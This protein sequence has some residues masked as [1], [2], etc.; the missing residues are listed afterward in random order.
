MSIPYRFMPWA[1]R[2]L[3]R[4][5]QNKDGSNVE[6]AVRPKI[7]VGLT[8][9]AKQDGKLVSPV[10][11]NVNLTLYGPGDVIGIDQRLIVRT[12]P[13][14]NITNFEPNYL[15]VIDFDPPD[16]PWLLTP[17]NANANHQL[18]P[19]LVLV[20]LDRSIVTTPP[21]VKAGQPLPSISLTAE[22]VA[23]ELPNLAES[24]LW[25]HTQAVLNKNDVAPDPEKETARV[26][27]ELE[28][29][30]A[31][32]VSRLVCPRRLQPRK[33]YLAC[34]VPAFEAGRM[35]G[36]GQ[37]LPPTMTTLTPAWTKGQ[38]RELPVYYHWEFSTGPVGDIE[39]L[40][41]RLKTPQQYQEQY[42]GDTERLKQLG[43][44]G[45]QPVAVDADH[46]LFAGQTP[47]TTVFEG[48][49][50]SLNFNPASAD[51]HPLFAQNLK[52]MLN[53]G[54]ALAHNGTDKAAKVPTLSPPIYG[55]HPAKRYS[56]DNSHVSDRWLDQLNLQPRYRLA[57]GWGAEVVRQNQDEFMQAAWTQVGEVL[58][59]QRALSLSRLA[60][61]VLRRIETRHL[62]KLPEHR[63]LAVL[64]PAR[65]RI[66]V[67]ANQSL[68]GRLDAATLPDELFDG[69]MR[70]LTSPRRSTFR[71]AQFREQAL[72]TNA[73][74]TVNQMGGLVNTFANAAENLAT[75]DPN[76]FV[77]DGIMGSRSFDNIPLPADPATIIDVQ[78]YTGLPGSMTAGDIRQI[79]LAN[80]TAREQ[81]AQ[82]ERTLPQIGDVLEKGLLTETHQL[83]LQELQ[84]AVGQPLKGDLSQIVQRAS[85]GGAEGVLL[86]VQEDGQVSAQ[87]LKI[88]G[89]DGAIKTFDAMA[90]IRAT[91]AAKA[92]LGTVPVQAVQQFGSSALFTTLP[93]GTL[94]GSVP[95]NVGVDQAGLFTPVQPPTTAL[96]TITL[97]PAITDP[98]VLQRYAE[99]F[100]EYQQLWIHPQD[101]ANIAIR[102]LNFAISQ[103]I[104]QVRSRIDPARTIPARV[105]SML[106]LA[107][108]SVAWFHDRGLSHDSL[109]TRFDLA[110]SEHLHYII[111]RTFDRV[112]AYPHVTFP[113]SKKLQAIAQEVFLPGVGQLPDDFIMAVETN[114]RFV[115]AFM[116][117]ANHEMGRE[118]LWQGFPTDQ[119]GT[120]FQHFWQRLDQ[121]VDID[122]IHRWGEATPLGKQRGSEAMLVL[123]IR[124]QLLERF[125]TLSIYAYPITAKE[126]RP[127]GTSPPV[128][129]GDEDTKE[130]VPNLIEKP[131]LKGHLG[132]DIT[133]VGFDIH[134]DSI[135]KFFFILEEQMTEPRFGFDEADNDG[136]NGPSWLDVDWSEVEVDPG[137]YFGSTNLKK[138]PPAK[139]PAHASQWQNPHAAMVADALLQRPFRGYYAG[140]KLKILKLPILNILL[141]RR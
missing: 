39:T 9:Q 13:K 130:I 106:S 44:I 69:A 79:I 20:V 70:R 18:R 136:R 62:S 82:S 84:Q 53:S 16:F 135:E 81:A 100:T 17:A 91:R 24:W 58:A 119:R 90:G 63:L 64:G 34:V 112:L 98:A 21:R 129:E 137:Q 40:A 95:I 56:V 65:A 96:R 73:I 50:V 55:G 60:H 114:P 75:I 123:L 43:H 127:G 45:E 8:L 38:D 121:K 140:E 83:R 68:Q 78:P 1:R 12:D 15:A 141:G 30:P 108:H 109:S 132:K 111:P 122:E 104:S 27:A 94:G 134:P 4:S 128:A 118:L 3:A 47:E 49:M 23:S 86:T 113:L 28:K 92:N 77:P 66:T 97:P 88:D 11:G 36:L 29:D 139:I 105:A 33:D 72:G 80:K 117:G 54:Q 116:L 57:A 67:A 14:P 125:P 93:L 89:S 138:A 35:R 51:Q 76:R 131:V 37:P 42:Q 102:P 59:A 110:S 124:G 5:H 103:S 6:L 31:L 85:F 101:Q 2:G 19:W 25:A 26:A 22:Q 133:Y 7:N 52:G 115:E 48:A 46:L 61:D 120:P 71:M 41:R 32:N 87:S 74:S 126:T 107:D 10:P 99:A